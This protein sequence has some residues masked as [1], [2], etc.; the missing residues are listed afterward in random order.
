MNR[1]VYRAYGVLKTPLDRL[2]NLLGFDIPAT[3]LID[4]AS[5][6]A[7][8]AI[9]RWTLPEKQRQKKEHKYAVYLNGAII[10]TVSIYESAVTIIGLQPGVYYIVRVALVNNHE[11]SSKSSPIRFYTKPSASQDYFVA[12]H[13]G[14][15]T[16]ADGI[17]ES[18][19][20]I[21]P[22][23]GLKDITPASPI[24]APM[25]REG[26]SGLA[27]R[28]IS[29]RRTSPASLG[30]GDKHDPQPDD[31]EAPEG[32]ESIQHLTEKLDSIRKEIEEVERQNKEE[33]EEEVRQKEELIKERDD[34]RAQL[35]EKDKASRNLKREVGQAERANTAAQN[36]RA[37]LEKIL[38]QKIQ[39]RQKLKDDMARWEHETASMKEDIGRL[40]E[41][42]ERVLEESAKEKETLRAKLAE[43]TAAIKALDDEAKEKASEIKKLER[44]LKNNSP[45]GTSSEQNLVQQMQAEAEEDRIWHGRRAQLHQ[46]YIMSMNKVEA[47]RRFHAEQVRYLE[48]LRAERRRQEEMMQYANSPIQQERIPRRGDSQ[49]SRHAPSRHSTSDSPR[50]STFPPVSQGSFADNMGAFSTPFLNISNGMTLANPTEEVAMSDEDRE[51]LTGGAMMSPGAGADLLP[52]DLFHDESNR[53]QHVK[54]LPGLGAL[55]GLGSMPAPPA[56][57]SSQDNPGPGPA[58]PASVSSRSPSVFASPQASQH[59]LHIGSPEGVMDSDRRSI[60]STRSN[61]APSGGTSSRFSG[62]FGIKQRSKNLSEDG[63]PLSKASSMPRQDQGLIG[64][65]SATRKRTSSIS[66]TVFQSPNDALDGTSDSAAA[67]GSSRKGFGFFS[68]EKSGGWPSSFTAFGR[69]PT[70]PRPGSTHSN[71]LPR[72]SVDSSR[73][74]IEGWPAGEGAA[75]ARNSPLAFGPGWPPPNQQSSRLYGSRHPS[76]RP[77]VQYGATGPP[78]DIME[79]DD[80]DALSADQI[81]TQAPIGTK[82]SASSKRANASDASASGGATG[83]KLNP[84]AKNFTSFFSSMKFGKDK[85]STSSKDEASTPVASTS[86]TPWFGP[87]DD[88]QSPPNSRKSRDTRSMTTTESSLLESGRTSS[89]LARTPSY[90]NASEGVSQGSPSLAGSSKETFMQKISRK[91]SSSKFTLPTFKRNSSRLDTLGPSATSA[92]RDGFM[93]EGVEDE[94][95]GSATGSG[96]GTGSGD[97]GMSASAG[98]LGKEGRGSTRGW[99]NVLK[100]GKSKKQDEAASSVGGEETG[101]EE[102]G[103][104]E[105]KS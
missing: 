6:K 60:R 86:S 23:R 21:R 94:E 81:S 55:P 58:S 57:S 32:A 80:S 30:L 83:A 103:A 14:Q 61:R 104:E 2:S 95:V 44:A 35:N 10:G 47:A 27:P 66:G 93:A 59:N 100:L 53:P 98:S 26:S 63:P 56:A 76:R 46:Q 50:M 75:G 82:P 13:D 85:T 105:E 62:M 45:D 92:P 77:S 74:G 73:W 42:K 41:E 43:E 64:L 25:A 4:L 101:E 72:P 34:L 5:I 97:M 68:R 36:E 84:N 37:K 52:A 9:V 1:L 79:D 71:E 65:D 18:V 99:S 90:S 19:P 40:R 88:E 48:S 69:R 70:S 38:A 51:K 54:P 31:S 15:D 102:S 22:Y 78:E 96:S 29:N 12:A 24:S 28:R 17:Q 89:D 49:R 39:D 8:G 87:D 16:D 67:P 33:E 91:S 11:F 7:D 20:R 3:P